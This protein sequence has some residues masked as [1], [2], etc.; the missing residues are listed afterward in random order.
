MKTIDL[1]G[2]IGDKKADKGTLR[3]YR[4]SNYKK[5]LGL[6]DGKGKGSNDQNTEAFFGKKIL[7][8]KPVIYP[9]GNN[10]LIE[11][12]SSAIYKSI[13]IKHLGINLMKCV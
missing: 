2:I 11:I 3:W 10:K 8:I 7:C 6:K 1:T 5:Q 13:K 9:Y 12:F 4:D